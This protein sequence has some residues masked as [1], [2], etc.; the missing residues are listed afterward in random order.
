MKNIKI[1]KIIAFFMAILMILPMIPTMDLTVFAEGEEYKHLIGRKFKNNSTVDRYLRTDPSNFYSGVIFTALEIPEVMVID[2]VANVS[3]TLWY[4]FSADSN[5]SWPANGVVKDGKD[6]YW[7]MSS[8]YADLIEEP[9]APE[10]GSITIK[11][12]NGNTVSSLTMNKYDK[13]VLTANIGGE[14]TDYAWQIE[15]EADKWVNIYGENDASIKVTYGMLATLLVDGK[16]RIRFKC[17]ISGE[18]VCSDPISVTVMESSSSTMSTRKVYAEGDAAEETTSPNTNLYNVIINYVFADGSIAEN[19]YTSKIGVSGT[20]TDKVTFPVIQG[21]K[22]T[23]NGIDTTEYQFNL[24]GSELTEDFVLNVV[25]Q[26][27]LVNYTVIVMQ[28]NVDNDNYKQVASVTK[29]ALTGTV[30]EADQEV[31]V[32]YPGFYQLM[33]E[34]VTVAASGN[35]TVEV[36]FDRYYYLMTFDMGDG[37]YGVLPV[38]ARYGT[39]VEFGNPTRP[40]WNFTHWTKPDGTTA[41]SPLEMPVDGIELTAQYTAG[42]T[43]YSVVYWKENADPNEDG[44]YGYTYW[45]SI[46]YEDVTTGITV[47]GS[48]NIPT[49]ITNAEVNGETVNEK[50]YFTYNADLTDMNVTVKGDGS[51]VVNVY[52]TRN[53]YTIYFR[54]Y[55]KCGLPE[56]NHTSGCERYLMCPITLHVHSEDCGARTLTCTK[57]EHRVHTSECLKCEE[58][59]HIHG[60]DICECSLEGHIHTSDCCT[61][62]NHSHTIECYNPNDGYGPADNND[63]GYENY[64]SNINNPKIGYVY[65][66][67]RNNNNTFYF[68]DGQIWHSLGSDS[69][70]LTW[71][72]NSITYVKDRVYVSNIQSTLKCGK[73]EHLCDAGDCICS[74]QEHI[75]GSDNCS[76]NI[77]EHTHANECYNDSLHSHSNSCFDYSECEVVNS[78]KHTDDCY[79]DCTL[80]AHRHGNNC[81]SNN[82][83]NT[84][85]VITAKYEANIGDIWP[86]Y[87]KLAASGSYHYKNNN[88]EAVD[89]DGRKFR[90]WDI[91][92]ADAEAVSKRI[93]MTPDLCNTENGYQNADAQYGAT[94][95]YHLYYM[96]ESFDQTSPANGTTR[97]QYK[98]NGVTKYYDSDPTYYQELI[99]SSDTTFGQKEILG[100]SPKGTE[101]STSGS[102]S[103][104]VI[105]N[106]LYYDR[107]R[108]DIT[109]QS[110]T[111]IIDTKTGV[112]F[113]ESL[114]AYEYSG[115]PK[116]PSTLEKGAYEFGGWYTTAGCY[117][118]TEVDFE[119]DTMPNGDII[120]YAKWQP[121]THTVEFYRQKTDSGLA[122]DDKI[123][124]TN[125]VGHGSLINEQY[126]PEAPEDFNN[127]E[128]SFNGWYYTD[129]NGVEYRYDFK[130]LPVTRDLQVYAKWTSNKLIE[131]RVHFVLESDN[132][133]KVADSI[134]GSDLAGETLTF[135]AKGGNDL[136]PLYQAGYYPNV[137]SDSIL[138]DINDVD[139]V[140]EL[141]FEY[142]NVGAVPYTVY[143]L[144]ETLKDGTQ[145]YGEHTV[146]GK[147]YY[148]IAQ[149]KTVSDNMLAYVSENF[150]VVPGYMPDQYQKNLIIVSG[151][152]NT[153]I[154]YYSIDN[155]NAYYKVTHYIQN[156]DGASWTEYHSWQ[157]SGKIG[158]TISESSLSIPGFTFDNTVVGTKVSGEIT[159]DGLE[160]KLYYTRNKYPYIVEYRLK[161]GTLL[162][163][164]RDFPYEFYEKVI[165]YTAPDEYGNYELDDTATK[166]LNIRIESDPN[167]IKV[168]I[169][170]FYYDEKDATIKYVP[171]GG[172]TV[173]PE[174][175][176]VKIITGQVTGSQAEENY[177]Y[178]FIGWFD[179]PEC[180]GNP[181][182]TDLYYKPEKNG[183]LW[184]DATYYAKFK[185]IGVSVYYK[186]ETG[187]SVSR[188]EESAGMATGEFKG[189]TATAEN[190]Y[191]FIGWYDGDEMV[192][193]DATYVPA[194]SE[195]GKTFVAK[196]EEDEIEIK[197]VPVGPD[198]FD[199][200]CSVS[201][202]IETVKVVT[203]TAKGS[204]ASVSSNVYRF[205]GWY[206]DKDCKHQ[207]GTNE[208][209]IPT[210]AD[211]TLWVDGTIYY[212]K[213]E[214]NLTSLTIEKSGVEQY[215]DIDPNQTFIFNINGNG[216]DLDVTVHGDTWSV[217]VDG[218]T[219]G[220]EYTITEKT[221][222]SWR[223]KYG[224]VDSYTD[225][226]I[227]ND[228]I[229][230]GVK[231]KIGLDGTITFTN[232]R[233]IDKWLDGDSWL[234][235]LFSLFGN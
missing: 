232:E 173:N 47:S 144:A 53:F 229:E 234:D 128:Y 189:S 206:Y 35:T 224:G 115:T 31:D 96:F 141:T 214:Y 124:E 95:K 101:K 22:A 72:N 191:I 192:S 137:M 32:S 134:V 70:G 147:K 20:I 25:Y 140:V 196:F 37:G 73:S 150:K 2:D 63:N 59:E 84:I 187:G 3:G 106:W 142:T 220:A 6:N 117:D 160:L 130:N 184:T 120:L 16:V 119:K 91:P 102:G 159:Q 21:Y 123:G 100:M 1:T 212:A 33:H 51:T 188:T 139:G 118:G 136:Y 198:G 185:E 178:K 57:T 97:K 24:K 52:Y 49:S 98:V 114:A 104:Y 215:K 219:V 103:T 62:G 56:H 226:T 126:I 29:Q 222:W 85:Y 131:Y 76:C 211:G 125:Y 146:D 193:D 27:T 11:D 58:M 172:G 82:T 186:A 42:K 34:K 207:V 5:S 154:F 60:D 138:L 86:T 38:Y 161:D 181:L 78:H 50:K 174:S 155:E 194:I 167:D 176:T 13:P 65:R 43:D 80:T 129:E 90:G 4:K 152:D 112:M 182:T 9:S 221:D 109:Y 122:D 213:F 40:G 209:Y 74:I 23:L 19:P 153:L 158:A 201:R 15:Y 68:Y 30:I 210:K 10:E 71:N 195:E 168:N 235:N 69:K 171:V 190:G 48:D 66:Y 127:G 12:D 135:D 204:T 225:V 217:T 205:V 145:S 83:S 231:V 208:T 94:Y 44:T 164:I 113:G 39:E 54:G 45:G 105:T 55:G 227:T 151:G 28:Q 81:N 156:L 92:G 200:F 18:E 17:T 110:K 202:E 89:K 162:N 183:E 7:W 87:D 230:N 163:T 8:T 108:S 77:L 36:K 93:N 148:M 79:S 61:I 157:A 223:Y 26:P 180:S 233:A 88:G 216:V 107:N 132:N 64:I 170:T 175:E 67:R 197:Y 228:T 99:Y 121:V 177:G 199:D 166:T 179:N 165:S 133:I 75:H 14:G 111:D 116:Y 149:T 203:G 218:L 143:Y 41:T 169:I 46:I